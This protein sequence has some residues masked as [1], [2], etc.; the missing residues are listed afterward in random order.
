MHQHKK[1]LP[2]EKNGSLAFRHGMGQNSLR[3]SEL[4]ADGAQNVGTRAQIGIVSNFLPPGSRNFWGART[5]QSAR[6]DLHVGAS[7]STIDP[8]P[9]V[10]PSPN[11]KLPT[12]I[13]PLSLD[14]SSKC[15]APFPE[16]RG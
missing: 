9:N 14:F 7:C 4:W 3:S 2:N 6:D 13:K 15:K 10:K 12:K 8:P 16:Q 5:T 1:L 11:V